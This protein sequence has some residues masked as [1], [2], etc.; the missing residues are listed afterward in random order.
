MVLSDGLAYDHGYERA[1][2][3]ADARRALLEAR[4]RGTGC[5]CLTIGA[6]TDVHSLRRVFGS[7]A[8]ATLGRPD[9]LAGVVGPLFRS[10][11]RSAEARRAFPAAPSPAASFPAASSPAASGVTL[12]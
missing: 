6:G 7:T 3:A 1:Y 9:Q 8:H 2:G 5:V 4:R 12:A 10:A 11:L